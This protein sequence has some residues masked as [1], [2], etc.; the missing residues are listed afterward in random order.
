VSI[1]SHDNWIERIPHNARR[2]DQAFAARETG[3]ILQSALAKL[4]AELRDTIILYD[5]QELS[6]REIATRLGIPIGTVKS[7][8]NRGRAMLAHFLRRHK[9]AA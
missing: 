3:R 8:L 4:P 6:Y 9:L 5:I 1:D 7:R 2:P